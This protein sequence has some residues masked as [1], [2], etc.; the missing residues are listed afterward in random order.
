[1]EGQLIETGKK[2]NI[3]PFNELRAYIRK[4]LSSL[5]TSEENHE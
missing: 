3:T 5:F 4:E 2:L 1:M